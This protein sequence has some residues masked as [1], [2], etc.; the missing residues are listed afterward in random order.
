MP[1]KGSIDGL[2]QAAR[3]A[4]EREEFATAVSIYTDILARPNISPTLA[5]IIH[6]EKADCYARLGNLSAEIDELKT[7]LTLAEA[8]PDML[9]QI[10]T[11]NR[12]VMCCWQAGKLASG[13]AYA[14]TAVSLAQQTSHLDLQADSLIK[15]GRIHEQQGNF[16]VAKEN[17]EQALTLA[18]QANDLELQG[19]TLIRLG[20][21]AFRIGQSEQMEAYLQEALRIRQALGDSE[22]EAS[23]YNMLGIASKDLARR[24]TY[25][26]KALPIFAASS[27]QER[28]AMMHNNLGLVYWG[29]GL[30]HRAH[31][32][33]KQAIFF[34]RE[35]SSRSHLSM[36][37]D[38]LGRCYVDLGRY[39]TAQSV[40]AEGRQIA[41]ETG[42]QPDEA[43]CTLGLGR[44]ALCLDQFDKAV[45]ELETAV[46]Q[47]NQLDMIAEK[48]AALA[49]LGATN[50]RLG[51]Q[52]KAR[53]Q[54]SEAVQLLQSVANF[55]T[56]YLP[57]EVWWQHYQMHQDLPE[58]WEILNTA[59]QIM[60]NGITHL[61]DEGLRRNYLNKVIVNQNIVHAWIK[62]ALAQQIPLD[63]FTN[64]DTTSS[65]VEDQL[66]R[67]LEI[68]IRLANQRNYEELAL[69]IFEEFIELS[70]PECALLML[71]QDLS[72]TE[73]AND[74]KLVISRGFPE[75]QIQADTFLTQPA[76]AK[77]LKTRRSLVDNTD[78]L[79][80]SHSDEQIFQKRSTLIIPLISRD[81]VWGFLYGEL[82]A[83]YG[84]FH[85]TDKNILTLLANQA[86]AALENSAWASIL[87]SQVTDRT[88]ELK[89]TNERLQRRSNELALI[90]RIGNILTQQFDQETL[91]SHISKELEA[92]FD[93]DTV[94]ITHYDAKNQLIYSLYY[95]NR[96]KRYHLAPITLNEG[97]T[98][99]II[100]TE[101]PLLLGT[102]QIQTDL[103]SISV[104]EDT[105]ESEE[106]ESYLGVPIFIGEDIIG[107]ISVQS[108]HRHA[109][110]QPHVRMLSTI[111][112]NCGVA[113]E[114]ARLFAETN[115]LL[116][117]TQQQTA[118][119]IT[120]NKVSRAIVSELDL[121]ALIELIGNQIREIFAADI[122]YV[123]LYDANDNIIH[124]PYI[125]GQ[126]PRSIQFG[127]GFTS[128]I[129]ESGLP[130]LINKDVDAWG[131][132]LNTE[133]IGVRSLSY[134]GV[135]ITIGADVVG[136]ISAQSTQTED[137]FSESDLHLLTTIA[138]HVGIALENARLFESTQKA[139]ATAEAA[140]NAKSV[141][142][143]S[144]SHDLRT[145]L[146]SIMGFTRLV[147][148]EG[149][150]SLPQKQLA[151]LDKVLISS[152]HLLTLINNIL[153]IAKIE[154]GRMDTI[155]Q[156]VDL[157]ALVATCINE[158]QP[159]LQNGVKIKTKINKNFPLIRTDET[160]V[161]QILS[162]L[163]S[164]AAKF[165][166]AGFIE[167]QAQHNEDTLVLTV[168]D[169]GIGI[170]DKYLNKIF[171]E[172][173]QV[174]SHIR[175]HFGGSGLG[176]PISR[177]LAELLGGTLTAVS[178]PDHGST[179][180]LTLPMLKDSST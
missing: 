153:D 83:I 74:F 161:H 11:L 177:S 67:M 117:E 44:V 158:V 13:M 146:S 137:R 19:N 8:S 2:L 87:E 159:L 71:H 152:E 6:T 169:T 178:E 26:E 86:A 30:Y 162:N 70:G 28:Q 143:A 20:S 166:E 168:M 120:V 72:T 85:E 172:F 165:T 151:N 97:L 41:Q 24:R 134:L 121:N 135:P 7:S 142:L 29:L 40:F 105:D 68:G 36:Y 114:N 55:S 127:E 23:T 174:D 1:H 96:G 73:V 51:K 33:F 15:L 16:A 115:R 62:Q 108:S 156:D 125:Y 77:A 4:Q 18:K 54:T 141:F 140:S 58:A 79:R 46:S 116:K 119:L 57:Q 180:T 100:Q 109:F 147:R 63:T 111:A 136:V 42:S 59:C 122:V 60:L 164:N 113:L 47:F 106:D 22:G 64:R 110:R 149:E 37:L 163:L 133:R 173:R 171:D 56:E 118:E 95:L 148:R 150:K 93:A 5:Y 78:T 49:W 80:I 104:A 144:M 90:N 75:E 170:P 129:I 25:F 53:Q 91:L 138:A 94:E 65:Q 38:S 66:Q 124:L 102:S 154:A 12:L 82:C 61:S 84:R 31:T 157:A 145:P 50:Q 131:S 9:L 107:T 21:V 34:A 123:A 89:A 103:G 139:Q 39:R 175:N 35:T 69:F 92:I 14:E 52:K 98:S 48:A 43:L 176:L 160:K 130:L 76:I 81:V 155:L 45:Q 128:R 88:A 32:Y 101:K 3:H 112:A 167:I 132:E 10:Q 17:F 27:N 126:P 99:I 179:F